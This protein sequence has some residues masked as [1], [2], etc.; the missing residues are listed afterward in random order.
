MNG[1]RAARLARVMVGAA[2]IA[3]FAWLT[4]RYF[5]GRLLLAPLAEL[6]RQP[7]RFA[8]VLVV[9]GASFWLRAW[10]W[11]QYVGKP[12]GLSV[13]GRAVLLSLFVNHVAPVKIG[14][15][16][17]VAVLAR[18]PGVSPGEAVESVA[19]M[20]FLDMAMLGG[21]TV[22]GT[23]AYRHHLPR[24]PL[25]A[26]AV[27]AAVVLTVVVLRR[28]LR[29]ERLWRRWRTVFQGRRGVGIVAAVAAS[30]L[31]EAAVIGAVAET[32]GL[33]L[34]FWQA[35]W[36]NSATVSGQ[37]VQV[38]PGG[39]GTYEAVMA[40]ALTALGASGERAYAAAVV[41]HAVKFLFSYAAGAV[42]LAFWRSDWQVVQGVWKKGREKR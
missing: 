30:W 24:V 22:I 34:S 9:Y 36:V 6:A 1:K 20:R 3:L 27:A 12:L 5:D 31:C 38:A 13:Y 4:H 40:F 18:Q 19:V 26:A 35:V 23:Y 37:I 32:V 17:R 8:A 28:P 11:K 16:A 21:W 7:V 2:L 14:D 42:V 41:T 39:L 29:L 33:S 10:A 15:A 25:L